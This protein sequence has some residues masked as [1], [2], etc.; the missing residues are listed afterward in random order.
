MSRF[1]AGALLLTAMLLSV[2]TAAEKAEDSLLQRARSGDRPSQLMLASEFMFGRNGRPVNP[3]LAVYWY[4]QAALGGDPAGQYNLALC[5]LNGWGSAKR[6]AAAFR[7]FERAMQGGIAKAAIRYAAMLHDGV[8]A[9]PE[10][11]E[12]ELPEVKADPDR[13][14]AILRQ[15]APREKEADMLL[16]QF[17]AA[18]TDKHAEELRFRLAEHAARSDADP[19]MLIIYAAFLRSGAA[20]P[21]DS[22]LAVQIL[23]RAAATGNAEAM[24]QLA[25]IFHTGFGA[26][27]DHDRADKLLDAALEKNSPRAMVAR[28]VEYLTGVRRPH[29]PEQAFQWFQKAA[30][31]NYP[32]GLRHL[33]RCYV[34]GI[35]T[36]PDPEQAFQCFLAAARKDDAKSLFLLGECFRKGQGVEKDLQAAFFWYSRAAEKGDADGMRETGAALLAGRGVAPDREQAIQWLRRAATLGDRTAAEALGVSGAGPF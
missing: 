22:R 24:A 14:L 5:Y 2:G 26:E 27:I 10:D 28:G 13:A 12:G 23:E 3:P 7:Y 35:G 20:G 31:L 9:A 32:P 30:R 11:P 18:Q 36:R 19:E 33:G 25:E 15:H 6:P 16:V 29:D 1:R 4:R 17:L 34:A 8:E 21:G